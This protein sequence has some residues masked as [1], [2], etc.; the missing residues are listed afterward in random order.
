MRA[1]VA[2]IEEE[3]CLRQPLSIRVVVP[4]ERP[5]RRQ[6]HVLEAAP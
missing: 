3:V 6:V 1:P 4:T 5:V 2:V